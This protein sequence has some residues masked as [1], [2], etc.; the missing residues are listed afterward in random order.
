MPACGRDERPG[1]PTRFRGIMG[2]S[3]SAVLQPSSTS[4]PR[5]AERPRARYTEVE[6]PVSR[7]RDWTVP[8]RALVLPPQEP[9]LSISPG[10][11]GSA[12]GRGPTS[13]SGSPEAEP[14]REP[15]DASFE[16]PRKDLDPEPLA[17]KF[18]GLLMGRAP[19]A[20]WLSSLHGVPNNSRSRVSRPQ[21]SHSETRTI[22]V[23]AQSRNLA[24]TQQAGDPLCA[25]A[26]RCNVHRQ[27][28]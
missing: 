2:L 5:P 9:E 8:R 21:K 23:R 11:W 26:R 4:K 17:R 16:L 20:S 22:K 19:S 28:V 3:P 14:D 10:S 18:D 6:A 1:C 12:K 24:S 15:E 13:L 7:G 25:H 27:D